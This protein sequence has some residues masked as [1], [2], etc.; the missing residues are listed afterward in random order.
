MENTIDIKQMK[1]KSCV[2][3]ITWIISLID[4]PFFVQRHH[5]LEIEI[6]ID[7]VVDMSFNVSQQHFTK[8]IKPIESKTK[9]INV[10]IWE[11]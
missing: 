3:I 4:S 6:E 9:N 11:Q 7:I 5:I 8:T 10:F 2:F 1:I